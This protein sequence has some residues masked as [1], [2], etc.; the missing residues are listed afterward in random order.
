[1]ILKKDKYLNYSHINGR[2]R[3]WIQVIIIWTAL[4]FSVLFG[5]P[6]HDAEAQ[7]GIC[8]AQ[9]RSVAVPL[10]ELGNSEYI[11]MDGQSTGF[12]GGLYPD[13]SNLPPVDHLAAGLQRA[14]EII[15]RNAQG[16]PDLEK[17]RIGVVSVGMSN[18]NAEFDAFTKLVQKDV[19]INPHVVLINGALGGQTSDKWVD[20]TAITWQELSHTLQRM[21]LTAEQVQVAWIKET[22]TRG[23]DFPGKAQE[24]QADLQAIVTNLK[25]VFP[26]LQIAYLSSRIYSYTYERGLSPEPVAYETGFAVKW[27]IEDQING[28]AVLNYD[29]GKGATSAPILFWGPYLWANGE[30]PRVDDGLTWLPEDLTSDCTHPSP[31]GL[32]KVAG[33]LLKFFKEDPTTRTWF[34]KDAGEVNDLYLP[35]VTKT[36]IPAIPV[37]NTPTLLGTDFRPS[38]SPVQIPSIFVSTA[39]IFPTEIST[40]VEIVEPVQTRNSPILP[41]LLV[42]GGV[43]TGGLI[44]RWL[45][46]NTHP[47]G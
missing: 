36:S 41:V 13:G 11:R 27:L 24:L 23:G 9:F 18:T 32:T 3:R 16:Q 19:S 35:A 40:P 29:P 4:F 45:Y 8:A 44:V 37:R 43:F 26:N 7:S 31:A 14:K 21:N 6:L 12:T 22:R 46:R 39:K 33:M 17:G 1:M 25:A 10:T 47:G 15:P 34:L 5:A 38:S 42:V 2:S 28:S 20:P 30:V